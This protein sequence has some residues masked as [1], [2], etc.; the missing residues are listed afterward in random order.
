MKAIVV[1]GTQR[2]VGK[3]TIAAALMLAFKRRGMR[4]KGFKIGSDFID[5]LV[6]EHAIGVASENL[7]VYLTSERYAAE[8]VASVADACDVCVIDGISGLY[9]GRDGMSEEGSTAHV[10]KLINAGVLLV[11]DCNA[12]AR[13]IAAM[14]KGYREFDPDLDLIGVVFNKTGGEA[15]TIY[16]KD[17]LSAAGGGVE[18]FGGVPKDANAPVTG[19]GDGGGAPPPMSSTSASEVSMQQR[20]AH[21]ATILETNVDLDALLEAIPPY[22]PPELETPIAEGAEDDRRD[23]TREAEVRK[24][25]KDKVRIAVARDEAFCFYYPDNLAKLEE[26]G[27]ELVYFSPIAGDVL[28]ADIRGVIFGGG[29]PEFHAQ[30]L[31]KN[32]PLRSA[33]TAF[34]TSGGVVYG[35]GGGLMFL[36]QT[37]SAPDG[38]CPRSMCGVAPFATRLTSAIK[39]GYVEVTI[40]PGNPLFTPG[41]RVR[42]QTFRYSEIDGD[43]PSKMRLSDDN[44]G[45]GWGATYEVQPEAKFGNA[46]GGVELDGFAWNKVL[47]SYVHLHFGVNPSLAHSFVA[48]CRSVSADASETAERAAMVSR[49]TLSRSFGPLTPVNSKKLVDGFSRSKSEEDFEQ[50]S[51]NS[52]PNSGGVDSPPEKVKQVLPPRRARAMSRDFREFELDSAEG[53][54]M[55]RSRSS[56][57][58]Q[59]LSS[60]IAS[61]LS[62]SLPRKQANS[63]L[64]LATQLYYGN[65]SSTTT[66][67]HLHAPSQLQLPAPQPVGSIISLSP[68]ATSVLFALGL[69]DRVIGVTDACSIPSDINVAPK[70]IAR[71]SSGCSPTS[72]SGLGLTQRQSHSSLASNEQ[73]YGALHHNSSYGSLNRLMGKEKDSG[74]S[75]DKWALF[76]VNFVRHAEARLIFTPDTCEDCTDLRNS[77]AK[78]LHEADVFLTGAEYDSTDDGT[79]EFNGSRPSIFP[80][81]PQTLS[82]VLEMILQIGILCGVK[83]RAVTLL[84]QLRSRMR[85]IARV[86]STCDERPK[87][88]SLEGLKPLFAGGHWVPEMKSIAGGIDELQEPGCSAERLRW[89]QVLSYA[90]DVLLLIP[91]YIGRSSEETMEKTLEKLEHLASQPGWWVLPAVRTRRVFIL[92]HEMF[93]QAGP[94]LVDGIEMLARI[95]N[96]DAFPME[97]PQGVCLKLALE[98]GRSCRP[99]Q[100]RQ[101]FVEWR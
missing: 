75:S 76:D 27:A 68:S 63:E 99:K 40:A 9:D 36:S 17:S 61:K 90:P 86:V 64:D 89:E 100:L 92:A 20:I 38:S 58:M 71:H 1:G 94:Q 18:V 22:V 13:S 14:I 60:Q 35:E 25:S 70:I 16:L 59:M 66:N 33:V 43:R 26:A 31:L 84:T 50:K 11:V 44:R 69:G 28:P 51:S 21:M 46:A 41:A 52:S 67:D 19:G 49:R 56:A 78:Y 53:M 91:S 80:V 82:D 39:T 96:P 97:L 55:F 6:H 81:A 57:S 47:V 101:H 30:A 3:T 45:I 24:S 72:S 23:R 29:Y 15:H 93:C 12:M 2:G 79:I 85:T 7:D 37:L 54:G 87:V 32:R 4:V 73:E 74:L 8:R 77:T 98:D 62:S 34:A 83:E 5:P 48:A 10:A 88:L 42:G 95:L 65:A